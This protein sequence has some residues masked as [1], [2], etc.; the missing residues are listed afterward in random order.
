MT[1]IFFFFFPVRGYTANS[2]ENGTWD[3]ATGSLQ[4][5]LPLESPK[6]VRHVCG[7]SGKLVRDGV[8]SI[9]TLYLARTHSSNSHKESRCLAHTMLAH[10]TIPASSENG[11]DP[12]EIQALGAARASLASSLARKAVVLLTAAQCAWHPQFRIVVGHVT[13]DCGEAATFHCKSD[14]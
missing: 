13:K 4:S 11:E 12:P 6:T 2:Q 5:P 10:W 8:P 3:E 1:V 14:S 9:D 7:T